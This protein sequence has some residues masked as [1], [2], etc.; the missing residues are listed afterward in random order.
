MLSATVGVAELLP[1]GS[2]LNESTIYSNCVEEVVT[3]SENYAVVPGPRP[4]PE[5]PCSGSST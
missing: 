5:V 4:R 1:I 3:L 2:E